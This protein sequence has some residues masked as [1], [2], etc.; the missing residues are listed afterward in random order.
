M[1]ISPRKKAFLKRRSYRRLFA[2]MV[3][4]FVIILSTFTFIKCSRNYIFTICIDPGHG[5]YDPGATNKAYKINEKD[6]VLD[7]SLKLGE[8]LK[9]QDVKVI[10]TRKK[11]EIPWKNQRESLEG[12][13]EIS[14]KSNADIF[15]S[16]H[17]NNFPKS[18]EVKGT[19]IWCRFKNTEDEILATEINNKLS[20]IEYTRN[21]GLRYESDKSL[22]VL[23]NTAATSVLVELG[24]IS[25]PQD[26][27]FLMLEENRDKCAKA[28]AEAIMSYYSKQNN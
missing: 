22:Y 12:R 18:S 10:Y 26:I 3:L 8:I 17:I 25:N 11:D 2:L 20:D 28:I 21:R 19:E 7:I 27:E 14:N 1:N 15:I 4:I 24:Y 13:S 6:L 23:R 9:K 16:I 5:G